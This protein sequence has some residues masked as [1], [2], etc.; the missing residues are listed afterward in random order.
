M[1]RPVIILNL[2][3]CAIGAIM[4]LVPPAASYSQLYIA[5][6]A[7]NA[8]LAVAFDIT[9]GYAGMLSLAQA[10]FFGTSA[11]IV[12][13]LLIAGEYDLLYI[14]PVAILVTTIL[15]AIT[16]FVAVRGDS[17]G[18]LI[19]TLIFVTVVYVW[20]QDHRAITGGDDGLILATEPFRLFGADLAATGRYRLSMALFVVVFGFVVYLMWSPFGQ[21]L[22]AI[23][24][25]ELRLEFLGYDT[26]WIKVAAFAL[27]GTVAG[28]AGFVY[29]I[30]YQHVHT[31]QLHWTVSAGALVWAF[32]G[33]LGTLAGPVLGAVII[34]PFE[35]FSAI[36]IGHPKFF[37]GLV[38]IAMV[39][40]SPN[41]VV[42]AA[43]GL[44]GWRRRERHGTANE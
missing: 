35:D 26:R 3:V 2:L 11:Y 1:S 12:S 24:D 37:T 31:G 7:L 19:L 29:A 16:G 41:G 21:V 17:H 15:A 42:G 28:V 43:V 40:L 34:K 44:M 20:A 6:L 14:A 38:L 22:R 33:G 13:W 5:D 30:M 9:F 8:L 32:F 10:L 39:L 27:S 4:A 18:L 36:W 25:N 23:K